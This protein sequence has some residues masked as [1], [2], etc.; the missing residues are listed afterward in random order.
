MHFF[1]LNQIPRIELL[2]IGGFSQMRRLSGD[3]IRRAVAQVMDFCIHTVMV[4]CASLIAESISLCIKPSNISLAMLFVGAHL[5]RGVYVCAF[6]CFTFA[7]TGATVCVFFYIF[8]KQ[9]T[10]YKSLS[11]ATSR[12]N[13]IGLT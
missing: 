3:K 9:S 6:F 2:S 7:Y 5:V 8:F 10:N 11:A 13:P 1:L 12:G 4:L